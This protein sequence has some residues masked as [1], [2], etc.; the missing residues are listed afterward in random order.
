MEQQDEML[1]DMSTVVT[2][3]Q[4]MSVE[5]GSEL[6]MQNQCVTWNLPFVSP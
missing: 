2:R 6:E 3:L 4:A 5:M 1:E